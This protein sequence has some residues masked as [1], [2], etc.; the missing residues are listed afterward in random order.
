MKLGREVKMT[1][2]KSQ[3]VMKRGI[4]RGNISSPAN[5][6]NLGILLGS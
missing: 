6:T 4:G 5:V 1:G 3:L 2:S